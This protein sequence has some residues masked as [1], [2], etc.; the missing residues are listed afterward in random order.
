MVKAFEDAAFALKPEEI[1]GLVESTFG[2]HIIKLAAIK[3]E[4][5]RSFEEVKADIESEVKTQL[6]Q[7]R[8]SE[9]ATEFT[10]MVYE[11]PD[12]LKL[13]A[14]KLKLELRNASKVKRIPPQNTTGVLD[15]PKF[16][17]AIFNAES[18]RNKR[19]TEAI[20]TAPNTLVSG[21][22]ISH[23]AA[24]QLPLTDVKTK[25][26]ERLVEIQAAALTKKLGATRLAELQ[27]APTTV[28]AEPL[29][30]VSRLQPKEL[31][32]PL[33][34]A[35]LKAPTTS[36]PS[37]V[38]VDLGSQGYAIVKVNKVLGRD[39]QASD[40]KRMQSQYAQTWGDTEAQAYYAALKTRFSVE[41]TPKAFAQASDTRDPADAPK[42]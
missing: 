26:H 18:V 28:L 35:I 34:E 3:P 27:A 32:G 24:R 5:K 33:L 6:A 11:Q 41:I 39:P 1:S 10:N 23:E 4:V 20:Q 25:V 17:T 12:N 15:N 8:F 19:N 30:T 22:V 36:L 14:D 16:L 29:L 38:S 13:V 42:Q 31:Q 21:R 9:V 40:M 2:F 37:L 7:K